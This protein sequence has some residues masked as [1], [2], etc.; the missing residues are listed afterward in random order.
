MINPTDA[1]INEWINY[2]V[3]NYKIASGVVLAILGVIVKKT[4]T[5][6]DDTALAWVKGKLGK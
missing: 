4:K 6:V 5:K 2:I 3:I 1:N